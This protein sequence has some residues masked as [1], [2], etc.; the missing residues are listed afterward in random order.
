MEQRTV[1]T[2]IASTV[3]VLGGGLLVPGLV[4]GSVALLVSGSVLLLVA[5]LMFTSLLWGWPV[6]VLSTQNRLPTGVSSNDADGLPDYPTAVFP[7]GM[8]QIYRLS[9]SSW[10]GQIGPDS[11]EISL[12]VAIELPGPPSARWSG[13]FA[14]QMRGQQREEWL[15]E[16][17]EAAPFTAWLR[18]RRAEWP[19]DTADP[20]WDIRGSG[21]AELTELVFVPRWQGALKQPLLARCGVLTG[22]C[23]KTDGEFKPAIRFAL[24]LHLMIR[25]LD[26]DRRPSSI[27][28]ATTPPPAPAALS[29]DELASFLLQ[30][31]SAPMLAGRAAERLLASVD[32]EHGEIGVW[33]AL[34]G[35]ELE[36]VV[37]VSGLRR[38]ADAI[39]IGEH[40][41]VDSW[42]LPAAELPETPEG[43]F[44]AAFMDDLLERAGYRDVQSR[45]DWVRTAR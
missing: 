21:N 38:V 16:M 20:K 4:N 18:E 2:A 35:V 8:R 7:T 9:P 31:I 32:H 12:R 43:S 23:A 25:E 37:N 41:R 6:V 24:D 5:L 39:G 27:R 33:I 10:L 22:W 11:P 28:H 40:S 15:T 34:S 19:W 36:R 17:L 3:A 1:V 13:D 26:G 14:T 42:P 44:V 29:L 30:L 45:F